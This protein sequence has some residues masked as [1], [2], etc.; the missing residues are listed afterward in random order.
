MNLAAYLKDD[1]FE[2]VPVMVLDGTGGLAGK[3]LQKLVAWLKDEVPIVVTTASPKQRNVGETLV[4]PDEW[5]VVSN[6]T[7]YLFRDEPG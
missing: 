5:E 7:A 4:S 3:H 1:V 2:K 6:S